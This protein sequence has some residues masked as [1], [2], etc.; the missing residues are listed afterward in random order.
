M[1]GSPA[2]LDNMGFLAYTVG[3]ETGFDQDSLT[4]N[5]YLFSS[6]FV[7]YTEFGGGPGILF[8]MSEIKLYEVSVTFP[9]HFQVSHPHSP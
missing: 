8:W 2:A 6:L 7:L 9:P 1:G 5:F 3:R 4:I